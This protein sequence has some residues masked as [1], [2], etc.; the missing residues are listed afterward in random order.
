M[1]AHTFVS[2]TH[3]PCSPAVRASSAALAAAMSGYRSLSR[4]TSGSSR[5]SMSR[6]RDT[7]PSVSSQAGDAPGRSS[8][9]AGG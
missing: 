1:H 6:D 9:A 3:P 2:L 4:R 7:P 8:E 5:S